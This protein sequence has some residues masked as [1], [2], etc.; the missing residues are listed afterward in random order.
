MED[1]FVVEKSAVLLNKRKIAAREWKNYIIDNWDQLTQHLQ[2]GA[3]ILILAGRHG[4]ESG[5]I[6]PSDKNL[7]STHAKQVKLDLV[8]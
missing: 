4:D 2:S 1:N 8:I 7:I 6:G 3:T 5:S